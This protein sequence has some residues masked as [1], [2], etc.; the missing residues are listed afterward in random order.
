MAMSSFWNKNKWGDTDNHYDLMH[1]TI[2]QQCKTKTYSRRS[3]F[4]QLGHQQHE[5][6]KSTDRHRQTL[7]GEEQTTQ[8]DNQEADELGPEEDVSR[9]R[10][11]TVRQKHDEQNKRH[12]GILYKQ[13]R[14]RN[15]IH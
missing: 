3:E 2:Q 10:D 5:D 14:G 15:T 9:M 6:N 7:I 13:E 1:P 11:C 12:D 8:T 4:Q